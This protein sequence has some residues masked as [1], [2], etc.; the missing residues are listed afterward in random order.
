MSITVTVENDIIRL[1]ANIHCPN[2]TQVR[3]ELPDSPPTT[4]RDTSWIDRSVGVADTGLT[5]DEILKLTRGE[6]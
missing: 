1:P 3:L 2:G 6:E 5:T 4:P